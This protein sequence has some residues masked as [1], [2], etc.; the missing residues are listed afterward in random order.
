MIHGQFYTSESTVRYKDGTEVTYRVLRWPGAVEVSVHE[1]EEE[2]RR[3]VEFANK[4]V[5]LLRQHEEEAARAAQKKFVD[6]AVAQMEKHFG[7]GANNVR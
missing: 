5:L 7:Q 1:T 4:D 3:I 6:S 2:A